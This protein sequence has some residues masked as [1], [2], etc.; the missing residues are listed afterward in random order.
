MSGN[1][2]GQRGL[3]SGASLPSGR[4]RDGEYFPVITGLAGNV[5]LCVA[6]GKLYASCSSNAIFVISL[7]TRALLTTIVPAVGNIGLCYV[8]PNGKIYCATNGGGIALTVVDPATDTVVT[9]I[10]GGTLSNF[11]PA[12]R[13]TGTR[14]YWTQTASSNILEFNITTD[15]LTGTRVTGAA[16]SAGGAAYAASVDRI[17]VGN[18]TA[19]ANCVVWD[20]N[21]NAVDG[22]LFNPGSAS[23]FVLYDATLD[24]VL[25][26]PNAGGGNTAQIEVVRPVDRVTTS[27]CSCFGFTPTAPRQVFFDA[28]NRRR[29]YMAGGSAGQ[30]CI[31]DVANL[32]PYASNM[33]ADGAN[34]PYVGVCYDAI[35]DRVY[36]SG[37]HNNV[38]YIATVTP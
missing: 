4:A 25:F 16:A 30:F 5:F 12:Y 26:I 1:D 29:L 21:T 6:N 8:A 24:R 2:Q 14:L 17:F 3:T 32:R 35:T 19:G 13:P 20:P 37:S 10:A 23:N 22:A 31:I 36:L 27:R 9:Q 33:G 15:T 7:S 11:I 38:S 28:T 34:T 18:T